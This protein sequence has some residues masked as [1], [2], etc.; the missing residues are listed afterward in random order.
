LQRNVAEW[1]AS[2]TRC[3]SVRLIKMMRLQQHPI[4]HTATAGNSLT[5]HSLTLRLE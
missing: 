1:L 5:Y 2:H 4:F 3:D